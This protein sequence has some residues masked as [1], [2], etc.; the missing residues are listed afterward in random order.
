MISSMNW[1]VSDMRDVQSG[2]SPGLALKFWF[3]LTWQECLFLFTLI[4]ISAFWFKILMWGYCKLKTRQFKS[5]RMRRKK[6]I[7]RIMY[8]QLLIKHTH[9]IWWLSC[10]ADIS[11]MRKP[12]DLITDLWLNIWLTLS[13]MLIGFSS[14][15]LWESYSTTFMILTS[16]LFLYFILLVIVQI[17]FL[18]LSIAIHVESYIIFKVFLCVMLFL[19]MFMYICVII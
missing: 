12:L 18:H 9:F 6:K 3:N 13:I 1:A 4:I 5:Y 14:N 10:I 16:F 19:I 8:D 15:A 2:C 7:H 17:T 11:S